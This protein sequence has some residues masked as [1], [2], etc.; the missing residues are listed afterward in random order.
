MRNERRGHKRTKRRCGQ[1][2]IGRE[3]HS[4]SVIGMSAFSYRGIKLRNSQ[5]D[6]DAATRSMRAA[7]RPGGGGVTDPVVPP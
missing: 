4:T 2:C 6:F 1:T 7:T 3:S 5:A